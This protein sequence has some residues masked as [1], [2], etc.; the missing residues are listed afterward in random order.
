ME[1]KKGLGCGTALVILLLLGGFVF[2]I[3]N[4]AKKSDD[5]ITSESS[6]V[7]EDPFK[8]IIETISPACRSVGIRTSKIKNFNQ[9]ENWD[10][11][12]QYQFSYDGVSFAACMNEDGTLNSINCG[13]NKMYAD[14]EALICY[15]NGFLVRSDGGTVENSSCEANGIVMNLTGNDCSYVEVNVGYYDKNGV[16]ITSG[17]DNVLNLKKGE[18]WR[19]KAYGF[20]DGI[21]NFKIENITWY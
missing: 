1:E 19:F 5:N 7:S 21:T 6:V 4:I 18:Q 16:K 17:L 10:G 14:G 13:S 15:M 12:E 11:G 8:D 9:I 2:F 20:G 3:Q